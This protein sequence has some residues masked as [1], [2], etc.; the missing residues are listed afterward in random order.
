MSDFPVLRVGALAYWN[1]LFSGLVPC[2]VLGIKPRDAT[3][4][5][6]RPGSEH[7]VTFEITADH[8]PYKRGEQHACWSLH[9]VPCNAI[10]RGQYFPRITHYTVEA[11]S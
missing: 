9:I 3:R 11:Q 1:T 6:T 7:S 10:K 2:K 5:E 8:G 4:K